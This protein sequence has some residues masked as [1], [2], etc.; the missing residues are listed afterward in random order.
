MFRFTIRDVLWLTVVVAL[1]VGWWQSYRSS[2]QRAA[3]AQARFDELDVNRKKTR[4]H[5]DS[6][7]FAAKSVG[8]EAVEKPDGHLMITRRL[9]GRLGHDTP[10][11]ATHAFDPAGG[12][13]ADRILRC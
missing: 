8:I 3:A 5:F 9:S 6:L 10:V 2:Q 1:G 12:S 7:K 11:H 13:A 4:L